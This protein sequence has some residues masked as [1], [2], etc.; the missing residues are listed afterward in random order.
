MKIVFL[1]SL[2]QLVLGAFGALE[3]VGT[4]G[5]CVDSN[6]DYYDRLW[7]SSMPHV[8]N[9]TT[10]CG[11]LEGC[12]GFTH[13]INMCFCLFDDGT[14]PYVRYVN[15]FNEQYNATGMID[16]NENNMSTNTSCYRFTHTITWAPSTS[17][18]RSPTDSPSESPTSQ[19]TNAPNALG[20]SPGAVSNGNQYH[21]NVFL[22]VAILLHGSRNI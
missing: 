13:H 12:R 3:L 15:G 19:P 4:G 14:T 1:L 7:Y 21:I 20:E 8:D 6:G 17:P 18:T 9:C 10:R 16:S 11:V 2:A 22:I 5:W